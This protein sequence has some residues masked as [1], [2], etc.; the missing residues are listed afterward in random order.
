MGQPETESDPLRRLESRIA[1]YL[2]DLRAGGSERNM[3]TL[4]NAFSE[5][6]YKV[7]LYLGRAE[8]EFLPR[9]SRGVNVIDLH[10]DGFM[11]LPG[12][13][14]SLRRSRPAVLI[15]TLPVTSW[16]A[17]LAARMARSDTGTIIRIENTISRRKRAPVKKG[18]EFVLARLIYPL[19]DQI[20]AVSRGVAEDFARYTGIDAERVSVIYNPVV[21]QNILDRASERVSHPWFADSDIQVI[22]SAGR[23]VEQKN[24]RNLLA[25]FS[26]VLAARPQSRLVILG[27]GPLRKELE[28]AI[29]RLDLREVVWLPG[30]AHNPFRYMAKADVFALSSDWEGLPTVLIEAMA[31]GCPVVSTDCPSGPAEILDRGR[32]GHLVPMNDPRALSEALLEVLAGKGKEV[33]KRWMEQFRLESVHSLWKRVVQAAAANE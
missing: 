30:F 17:M 10:R 27:E 11:A 8:G 20:V 13:A 26:Y 4:A 24:H 14:G 32:Y 9:L 15:S 3:A 6:G 29:A 7:D 2:P 18:L 23:L 31:C 19:A 22:L 5:D 33:D 28:S 12:L 16:V 25:A 1:F 21:G